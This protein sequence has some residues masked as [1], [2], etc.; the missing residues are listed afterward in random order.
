MKDIV[1]KDQVIA[2]FD[3]GIDNISQINVED[4]Y[5]SYTLGS[6][7]GSLYI[8]V[9]NNY[10]TKKYFQDK[11]I[12]SKCL[13][14]FKKD[15]TW[16]CRSETVMNRA[17]L[18]FNACHY[19]DLLDKSSDYGM[20]LPLLVIGLKEFPSNDDIRKGALRII[21]NSYSIVNDKKTIV[22]LGAVEALA[23]LLVL[24]DINEAERN[25]ACALIHK[26]TAP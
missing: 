14:V 24:E 12:L 15:N 8:I 17:I 1:N 3:T 18:L 9:L 16:E 21:D 25:F 22:R 4:I 10:V 19:R 26:I 23:A 11:D 13:E 20:L 6:V 7:L 5:N 2:I